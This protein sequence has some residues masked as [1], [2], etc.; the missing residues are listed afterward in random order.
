MSVSLFGMVESGDNASTH[1]GGAER[2]NGA[3][4]ERRAHLKGEGALKIGRPLI[5]EERIDP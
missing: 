3:G 1:R 4:T 2:G 5:S